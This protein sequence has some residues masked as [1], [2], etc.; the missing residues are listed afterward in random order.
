MATVLS[1]NLGRATV[2]RE[3]GRPTGIDKRPVDG[4]V[5]LCA[6]GRR[7][8][9]SGVTSDAVCDHRHHGGD[10]QA[11]YAYAR[12]DLDAWAAT[13]G[14]PLAGGTFGENLTTL[15][16]DVTGAVIGERW[17]VGAALLEVSVPRIPCG[18]FRTWM[19]ERRWLARFNE[20][21]RPGAYL[22]VVSPGEVVAGDAVTV[23]DRPDHGIDIGTVFGAMT[24]HPE[25]LP[26]IA[27]ADALPVAL[28]ELARSAPAPAA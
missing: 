26:R 27:A 25:L 28:L 22:R 8:H 4:P 7:G 3:G 6:P 18:V 16:V 21:G 1:V 9:G 5:S 11:V 17:R 20:A 19:G 23:E 10:D 12:E 14:R 24:L 15:G 13:L 2:M